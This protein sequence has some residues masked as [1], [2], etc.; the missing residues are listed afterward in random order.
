MFSTRNLINR[1]TK[2]NPL[3]KNLN[4]ILNKRFSEVVPSATPQEKEVPK[5]LDELI[6]KNSSLTPE[7]I[8]TSQRLG[9]DLF[10]NQQKLSVIENS[11]YYFNSLDNKL[12]LSAS[13]EEGWRLKYLKNMN[14]LLEYDDLF[15]EFIQNSA[16]LDFNG[17]DLVAE[18]RFGEFMKGKLLELKNYGFNLEIDTIKIRQNYKILR[19]EIYKNLS[20]DRKLNGVYGNYLFSKVPTGLAPLVVAKELGKDYSIALNKKP[21]ILATTMLVQSP[22]KLCIWNQNHTKE[23]K[24][25]EQ[26]VHEYVVRFETQMTYSD[27]GWILPIQNKPSRLRDTKITDFNNVLRGNPYFAENFDLIDSNLRYKYMVKDAKLDQEV[28]EVIARE[29][30]ASAI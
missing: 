1:L 28:K 21:F 7:E 8:A 18:P 22:I 2:F 20:I 26:D 11:G 6:Y 3:N 12:N 27:F 14:L 17:I 29:N 15:R 19:M 5:T 13:A 23:F 16:R 30:S 4:F 9:V 10:L 24:L 25:K